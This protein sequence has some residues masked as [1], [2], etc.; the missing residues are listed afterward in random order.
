M[1]KVL[2]IFSKPRIW[3]I[4]TKPPQK[5]YEITRDT[6]IKHNS[7]MQYLLIKILRSTIPNNGVIFSRVMTI[8]TRHFLRYPAV[9]YNLQ[10]RK[11]LILFIQS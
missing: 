5:N 1:F 10:H 4:F 9:H 11:Q 8:I 7:L 6:Q 3:W 2:V